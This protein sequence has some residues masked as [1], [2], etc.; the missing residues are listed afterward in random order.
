MVI[1]FSAG[2]LRAFGAVGP[3]RNLKIP[4][5]IDRGSK[6]QKEFWYE[7]YFNDIYLLGT[8]GSYRFVN[9][10]GDFLF[11]QQFFDAEPIQHNRSICKVSRYQVGLLDNYGFWLIQPRYQ[12][13]K[14]M[15]DSIYMYR[16]AYKYDIIN[17]NGEVINSSPL[18]FYNYNHGLVQM[19]SSNA[20]G[21]YNPDGRIIYKIK[22]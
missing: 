20:V 11:N 15:N 6:L 14:K 4:L 12:E 9:G 3:Y 13:L 5:G 21:Y 10:N 17:K 7:A 18:D 8:K 1:E 19:Q 16:L 2:Q 22:E